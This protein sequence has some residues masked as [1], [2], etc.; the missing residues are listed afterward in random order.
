MISLKNEI[1]NKIMDGFSLVIITAYKAIIVNKKTLLRW[2]KANLPLFKDGVN[3]FY[4][5]RGKHFDF[6]AEHGCHVKFV[7]E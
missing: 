4:I 6:V 7:I 2:N 1:E 5:A 3:G